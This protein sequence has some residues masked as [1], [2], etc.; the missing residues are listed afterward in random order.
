MK[1]KTL[2]LPLLL[3][4]NILNCHP[5]PAADIVVPEVLGTTEFQWKYKD[6]NFFEDAL[7]FMNALPLKQRAH[8]YIIPLNSARSGLLNGYYTVIYP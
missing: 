8:A 6:F 2:L 5:L 4:V 1:T 3:A 7:N